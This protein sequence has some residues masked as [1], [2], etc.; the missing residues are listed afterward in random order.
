MAVAELQTPPKS[1][2]TLAAGGGVCATTLSAVQKARTQKKPALFTRQL[3]SIV[4]TPYYAAIQA[5]GAR[6]R[7][8]LDG[9]R[10]MRYRKSSLFLPVRLL[11]QRFREIFLR[12]LKPV[13]AALSVGA[14]FLVEACG[15]EFGRAAP[16]KLEK[17]GP[18]RLAGVRPGGDWECGFAAADEVS[19]LFHMTHCGQVV[20]TRCPVGG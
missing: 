10:W 15:K 13:D 19:A 14:S 6:R 4:P 7:I 5:R 20:G 18:I 17:I 2:R 16:G 9:S 1:G 12:H 8:S 3:D 11:S